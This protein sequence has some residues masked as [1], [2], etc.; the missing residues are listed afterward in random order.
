MT[1]ADA[2]QCARCGR[3]AALPGRV[4]GGRICGNCRR[5]LASEPCTGCGERRPVAGRGDGQKPWCG[6]CLRKARAAAAGGQRRQLIIGVVSSAGAGVTA[7]TAAAA[8]AA[9]AGSPLSLRLLA[10]HLTAHPDALTAGPTSIPAVLDRFVTALT[11]AGGRLVPVHPVCERCG[12]QRR[13]HTR[14]A[15]GGLCS[16]C[17]ARTHRVPCSACGKPCHAAHHDGEGRP[18][19]LACA[20]QAGQASRLSALAAEIASAVTAACPAAGAGA[21]TAAL[22]Q[23]A[24]GVRDRARLAA[25]VRNGPGLATPACRQ[26]RV[27]CLLDE[28]RRA[29]AGIPAAL[30]EDCAGPAEPLVID[31]TAA[32]CQACERDPRRG[33]CGGCGTGRVLLD[34]AGRCGRCRERQDRSCARC[35]TAGPRTWM[36]Q[37]WLCHR[38]ALGAQFDARTGLPPGHLPAGL[39]GVRAAVTTVGN[40]HI[41]RRWLRDSAGGQ[42]LGRLAAGDVP[43]THETLDQAGGNHSA[44]Y[45]RALL[46]AAGALPDTPGRRVERAG[47]HAAGLIA[48]ASID[49]ADARVVRAWLRWQLL[50]RLRRRADSGVPMTASLNNARLTLRAVLTLLE[51]TRRDGQTLADLTQADVDRW[52]ARPASATCWLARGFLTWSRARSHLPRTLTIPPP[53]PRSAR[54]PLDHE[55]RW[56]IARRLVTDD[57]IRADDRIAA[58][59]LVLYGQPLT[60][61]AWLTSDDIRHGSDGTTLAVLDGNPVPI[62]EPFATLITQLPIRRTS[63][64]ADQIQAPWLFPGRHAA[65]PVG[66]LILASRLRALGIS[67]AAMRNTARAQ[68]AAEIMPAML[69]ELIGISA[70]TAGRWSAITSSNW[71]AYAATLPGA[72]TVAATTPP[73]QLAAGRHS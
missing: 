50:P 52:F 1:G 40:F 60:R 4:A 47:S 20:D 64:I 2:G 44:E 14:T 31:R 36:C 16:P 41:T 39:A 34:H 49:A 65:R 45:L 48:A 12:L 9:A 33:S 46:I 53:P 3:T 19:C 55:H 57:T 32:R 56:A 73:A 28:L 37:S 5:I 13:R 66:P 25:Q 61:I 15:S 67:P 27:A 38:C 63:G 42:L 58:A 29:G 54:P 30:C 72:M 43:L 21:V 68:L 10:E 59:L 23:V 62:H 69:S 7:E 22:E 51:T 26:A 24:P 8:L 35:G 18:V 11:A 17:S 6:R 70:T 71:L